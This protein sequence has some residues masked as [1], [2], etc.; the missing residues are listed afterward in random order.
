MKK[1]YQCPG[2]CGGTVEV[3]DWDDD[4]PTC[5]ENGCEHLGEPLEMKLFCER[6]ETSFDPDGTHKCSA[7]YIG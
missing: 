3:E 1:M 6:C 4:P 5:S 7:N 2:S